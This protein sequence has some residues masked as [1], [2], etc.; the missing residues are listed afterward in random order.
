M[1]IIT[2]AG[3]KKIINKEIHWSSWCWCHGVS[4]PSLW[5]TPETQRFQEISP[6]ASAT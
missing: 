3:F 4:Y 2:Q 6:T 5:I 1:K